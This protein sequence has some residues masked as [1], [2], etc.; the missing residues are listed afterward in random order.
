[1]EYKI[2]GNKGDQFLVSTHSEN[3]SCHKGIIFVH[4]ALVVA[5]ETGKEWA[6]S[7]NQ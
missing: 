4:W 1:M 2:I 5:N 3:F 6:I 7:A